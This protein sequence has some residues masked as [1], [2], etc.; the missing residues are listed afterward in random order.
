MMTNKAL[1][2]STD[3]SRAIIEAQANGVS[4]AELIRSI[5]LITEVSTSSCDG[6]QIRRNNKGGG[7]W[8]K[9]YI[10]KKDSTAK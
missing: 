1:N 7:L 4:P 10:Y 5:R 3:I 9:G 6:V 8:I 2:A